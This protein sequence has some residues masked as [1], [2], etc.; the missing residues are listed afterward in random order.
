MID[1]IAASCGKHACPA[2][3]GAPANEGPNGPPG[4]G[5]GRSG[6]R[7]AAPAT[8]APELSHSSYSCSPSL[9]V[10]CRPSTPA[11]LSMSRRRR[12]DDG[13]DGSG[14]TLDVVF[15]NDAGQGNA[16]F[17]NAGDGTG[18][19]VDSG[20]A[21]GSAIASTSPL[22]TSTTTAMRTQSLPTPTRLP[23]SST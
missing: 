22:V 20:Q 7:R 9:P 8:G 15:A 12:R 10:A 3:F 6:R 21:L 16:V 2:R 4:R 14:G 17:L 19:L 5:R 23:P 13:G 1:M 11:F 18:T